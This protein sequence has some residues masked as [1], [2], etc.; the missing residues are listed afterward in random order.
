MNYSKLA[1]WILLTLGLVI[2]LYSLGSSYNIF[3]GRKDIYPIFSISENNSSSEVGSPSTTEQMQAVVKKQL[4]EIIPGN[5][6]PKLLNLTSWSI[7]A[8]ILIFG[9]GK[10]SGLGIKLISKS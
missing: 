10:I 4:T 8:G 6:L 7:L 9:G 2:I 1:G 5:A 3:T